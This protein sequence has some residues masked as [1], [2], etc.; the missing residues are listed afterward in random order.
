MATHA[1]RK[2]PSARPL[3]A[4][5]S[6]GFSLV[7]LMIAVFII[8]VLTT[9]AYSAYMDSVMRTRRAAAAGCLME[10]RQFMERFYTSNLRYDVTLAG[11]AVPAPTCGAGNDVTNFYTIA[12]TAGPT[13]TNYQISATPLGGQAARDTACAVL[14]VDQLG[15]RAITGTGTVDECF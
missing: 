9:I 1:L 2:R 3:I 7:E 15:T 11:A 14:R 5:A 6:R 12:F 10:V 4:G 8:A 13:A